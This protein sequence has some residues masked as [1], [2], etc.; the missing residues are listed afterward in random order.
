MMPEGRSKPLRA[1]FEIL[2]VSWVA[3]CVLFF[4][5]RYTRVFYEAHQHDIRAVLEW[6]GWG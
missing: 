5:I 1:F 3:V 4:Y 2:A 6:L